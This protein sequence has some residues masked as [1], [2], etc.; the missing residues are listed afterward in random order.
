M[1]E[2]VAVE[3]RC[4][5]LRLDK[6]RKRISGMLVGISRQ[7][8]QRFHLSGDIDP[9]AHSSAVPAA[10]GFRGE[11]HVHGVQ[12]RQFDKVTEQAVMCV[13]PVD[14]ARELANRFGSGHPVALQFGGET[15][16]SRSNER[17]LLESLQNLRKNEK[18]F[19][20]AL[21]AFDY[22]FRAAQQPLTEK[23]FDN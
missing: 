18:S 17:L 22:G 19:G 14:D 4:G 5:L 11:R 8:N 10:P 15:L 7:R 2:I 16:Q 13:D 1:S 23:Y 12:Q 6:R 20:V 21:D 3:K 9:R